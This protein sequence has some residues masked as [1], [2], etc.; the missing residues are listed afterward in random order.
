[1]YLEF[2]GK[3]HD[4]NLLLLRDFQIYIN[5]KSTDVILV[6]ERFV[7]SSVRKSYFEVVWTSDA[8]TWAQRHYDDKS[9][10]VRHF[11]TPP[12]RKCRRQFGA[13]SFLTHIEDVSIGCQ[14]SSFLPR[15]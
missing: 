13:H 14:M 10:V 12:K 4:E 9:C 3:K 5:E 6:D 15:Q 8:S 2:S 11:A 1:M 7:R